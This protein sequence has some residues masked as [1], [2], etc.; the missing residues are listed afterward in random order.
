M[1]IGISGP[2]FGQPSGGVQFE[3]ME[4]FLGGSFVNLT[5]IPEPINPSMPNIGP[6]TSPD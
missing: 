3:L 1:R 2:A 5:P 4:Q 6:K